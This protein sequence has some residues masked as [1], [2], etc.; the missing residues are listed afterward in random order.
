MEGYSDNG[1]VT[2]DAPNAILSMPGIIGFAQEEVIQVSESQ[3]SVASLYI[4]IWG[5]MEM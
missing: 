3:G 5:V 4:V 1:F 2:H